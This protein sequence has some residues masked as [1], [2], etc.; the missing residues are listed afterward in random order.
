MKKILAVA[1]ATAISAP[2]MADLTIG[3][4]ADY[5]LSS[6][7]G[8]AKDSLETNLD[9]TATTTA[10]NGVFAKAY[11]QL[12]SFNAG[13]VDGQT[14]NT[15]GTGSDFDID[16][17]YLEIGN[18]SASVK[19]GAFAVNTA[20]NS[21]DDDFRVAAP[22]YEGKS[23]WLASGTQDV[24]LTVNA[25]EGVVV[26]YAT[27]LDATDE[28]AYQLFASAA[29]GAVSVAVEYENVEASGVQDDAKTGFGLSASTDLSGVGLVVSYAENEAGANST[30]FQANYAGGQLNIQNDDTAAGVSE[31]SWYGAYA[32]PMDLA[33]AKITIGAGADDNDELVGAR[34][35]YKF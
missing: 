31:T 35:D 23:V 1:V 25:A 17:N 26:Q 15:N 34:I 9:F 20:F 6:T 5:F 7:S 3:G 22:S 11:L 4:S 33:G 21:G 18:A 2:A 32:L 28:E 16:D 8:D 27:T 12:E 13:G 30:V 14:A 10:D 19:V 24:A 29:L